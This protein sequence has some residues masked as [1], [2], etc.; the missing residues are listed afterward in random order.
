[1][2]YGDG[3]VVPVKTAE[4][5]PIKNRWRVIVPLGTDGEGRRKRKTKIV[6]GTKA[7]ARSVLAELSR[8]AQQGLDVIAADHLTFRELADMWLAVATR[9]VGGKTGKRYTAMARCFCRHAGSWKVRQITTQHCYALMDWLVE[10]REEDGY[11][12]SERTQVSYLKVLRR[13]FEH[14]VDGGFICRNPA[15]KVKPPKL[16]EVDRRSLSKSEAT[17][18]LEKLDCGAR[19]ALSK[20]TAGTG[21]L[22][23]ITHATRFIGTRLMLMTGTR[24]GEVLGMPW[25]CVDYAQGAVKVEQTFA[26]EGELHAPKTKAGIR[27]ISVDAPTMAILREWRGVQ[28]AA[29]SAIGVSI[30][31]DSPVF[32]SMKGTWYFTTNFDAWWAKWRE[33]NGLRGIVTHELR[34]TQASML[35]GN[36]VDVKTVQTR[37]GHADASVTLNTYAHAIPENDRKAGDLIGNLFSGEPRKVVAFKSA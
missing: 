10:A 28:E 4:G 5:K 18:L 22:R 11:P 14:G 20:L 16:P 3:S 7:E 33:E 12:I 1:M 17:A 27:T 37:L 21:S 32:P 34:H 30:G 9:D 2:A 8:D 35:L 25:R 19:E 6:H 13:I 23:E 24:I 29:L 31:G 15:K 36:G 26:E